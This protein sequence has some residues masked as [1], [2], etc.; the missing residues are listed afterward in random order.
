MRPP[1]AFP[2]V[3]AL[4]VGHVT[5]ARRTPLRHAFRHRSYQWLVC[6][7]DLPRLPFWLRPLASFH[8]EDHLDG[9]LSGGGIRGDLTAFLARQGTDL[10]PSDRVLM[11]ANARVLGHVFDPLSVLW[12]QAPDGAIRA[13]VFEVHNRW[14]A[15][16]PMLLRTSVSSTQSAKVSASI[17]TAIMCD[18]GFP[19]CVI[20]PA[21][22]RTN[23]GSIRPEALRATQ[24]ASSTTP[25]SAARR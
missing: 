11:L 25:A 24:S 19:S 8:A 23:L 15:P 3:P 12:V 21:Q 7:D 6:V 14:Q 9:G 2:Q 4:I 16:G 22:Q 17:Q 18:G 5:H 1:V 13:V 20:C 10:A